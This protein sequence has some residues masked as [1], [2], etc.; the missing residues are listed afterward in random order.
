[1]RR[2]LIVLT[3]GLTAL[4]AQA[5]MQ[6]GRILEDRN[7]FA[8]GLTAGSVFGLDGEVQ[9]TTR[10]IEVIGGPTSGAP[11]EDYSWKELGFDENA[12]AF[13]L[14]VEKMW[15]FVTLQ[16]QGSY[17][18]ISAAGIA[19]RDYFIGVEKVEFGGQSYEYMVIP[20]G[21]RYSGDIESWIIDLRML[22]TPVSFGTS[23]TPQF[24]PWVHIGLFSFIGDYTIDAGPARGVTQY[25]NPPRDYVIGGKGTGTSGFLVPSIGGGGELYLPFSDALALS[26]QAHIAFLKYGG[27]S[28][29]F[30]VSS[31]N[32]KAVDVDYLNYGLRMLVEI[33]LSDNVDLIAGVEF[34]RWEGDAEVRAKDRSVEDILARREKFDKDVSFEMSSLMGIVGVRF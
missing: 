21:Q 27:S 6:T 20:R 25:E 17:A 30:G 31:R 8:I 28:G 26:V 5:E 1:M 4:Q 33:A 19:D 10:P 18:E 24:T 9:E 34:Q 32:E 3:A 22:I 15:R 2:F 13:G 23:E 11:P 12:A 7:T 14:Y 16:A 29:D